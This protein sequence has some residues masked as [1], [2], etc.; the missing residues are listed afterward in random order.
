MNDYFFKPKISPLPTLPLTSS[1]TYHTTFYT[2]RSKKKIKTNSLNS[3]KFINSKDNQIIYNSA[4]D[5]SKIYLKTEGNY[6]N[7]KLK[8]SKKRKVKPFLMPQNDMSY[9]ETDDAIF[10]LSEIKNMDNKIAKR[11]N[12]N[13]IWKE[14]IDNIY[15]ICSSKNRND[16]KEVK[17]RVRQNLSA[18]NSKLKKEIYKNKFLPEQ[19]INIINDAQ[20]IMNKIKNNMIQERKINKKFSYFNK[21]DLYTFTKQN[22]DICLKNIFINL[23]KD[24]SNRIL[25]KENQIQKA[26]EEAKIDFMKDLHAFE[27]FRNKKKKSFRDQEIKL[28]EAVRKNKT[29]IEELKRY[30]SEMHGTKDEIDKN[31]RDIILYKL[32]ADFVHQI[33]PKDENMKNVKMDKIEM[34]NKEKDLEIIAKNILHEFY[35]LLD[36]FQ[37]PYIDDLNN[38]QILTTLFSSMESNIINS[39][40]ERD[41]TIKEILKNRKI[42]EKELT[43]LK[44]KVE[45]DKK[46]LD[47]LNTEIKLKNNIISPNSDFKNILDENEKHILVIYNELNKIFKQKK[48]IQNINICSETLNLL[49]KIEDKLLFLFGE[50][51]K[52]EENE[53][54]NNSDGVF[55][56][57]IDSVKFDNK[58]EKYL[59]SKE[60]AL[61][62]K[63]E[64]NKK[65]LQRMFRYKKRGPITFP[66]PWVLKKNKGN[67]FIKK[68]KKKEEEDI[69]FYE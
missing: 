4:K 40:E 9:V 18:M 62:L 13:L 14:K 50:L 28:E 57:I 55:K 61:K 41:L 45:S 51:D 5:N 17:K 1:T 34:L 31:I 58:I 44:N 43:I 36:D 69:L 23:I 39:M 67:N 7:E 11:V 64:K 65:Y 53:K 56:T 19:K 63:E 21:I 20:D 22:R 6:L 16:I 24:E 26:L 32:Y 12:K 27:E 8:K 37:F 52:I 48:N 3:H 54:D 2:N 33:I 66:P 49:H 38:P 30:S 59:E 29:I 68:D 47:E 25:T 42:Y 60:I 10:A 46:E 15:D 35:F